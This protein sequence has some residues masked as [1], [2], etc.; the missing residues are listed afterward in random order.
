MKPAQEI[1]VRTFGPPLSGIPVV[2]VNM[3]TYNH[4]SY[5]RQAIE[6]VFMQ[7]F[8]G[9]IELVIGED[10]ST[11]NTRAVIEAVC[12]AAPIHVRLLT[13]ER[14]VGAHENAART[15]GACRGKFMA[16]IDG[17]DYWTDPEKL[18]V[19]VCLLADSKDIVMNFHRSELIDDRSDPITQDN[20]GLQRAIPQTDPNAVTFQSLASDCSVHTATVLYRRSALPEPP[21][22]ISRLPWGD[23]AMY[24][25]LADKGEI[26]FIPRT[27]SKYRIHAGGATRTWNELSTAKGASLMFEMLAKQTADENSRLSMALCVQNL[28]KLAQLAE[29]QGN[30]IL[31]LRTAMRVLKLRFNLGND[32]T[33]ALR[34]MIG[35][36]LR[37]IGVLKRRSN[38]A[39]AA[40]NSWTRF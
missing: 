20:H 33:R 18:K 31:A 36:T 23:W 35:A 34:F 19:Q 16:L 39:K 6:S 40:S 7:D 14:N 9:P 30:L 32:S 27:M 11:D 24:L 28:F 3:F 2:S 1:C 25:L 21:D 8:D 17:D 38:L 26:R 13:S 15:L 5:I 10:C 12:R 29:E 4:E 22:W 37:R